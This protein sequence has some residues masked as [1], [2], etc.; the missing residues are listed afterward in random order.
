MSR[1]V[2]IALLFFLTCAARGDESK[3]SERYSG[4]RRDPPSRDFDF[5]H[6]RLECSFDWEKEEVEAA[7]THTCRAF[8]EGARTVELDQVGIQVRS[9]ALANGR[10]LSFETLPDKLRIDLGKDARRGE[11]VAFTVSYRARPKAG[12]YFRKPTE[13]DPDTPRQIWTQGEAEEA[14]HWI[15]C[16]D[17][18]SDKLTSE[19][20]VT[21]PRPLTAISNGRLVSTEPR[22][23]A[24]VFRWVQDKPHTTYLIVVVVGEFAAWKAEAEGIPLTAYAQKR[25]EANLA[26]SFE[27]TPDMIRFFNEKTGFPYPWAKYDQICVAGFTFGGMENTS[28]TTLNERTLHD[29]RASLDVSSLGLVAHELAHQWFGDLVTCKDWGDIWINE[30]FATFFE[31]LYTEHHL[32]WDEGVYERRGQA[33]SYKDEDRTEYRRP[34]ALRT[35]RRPEHLFDRHTYPKGARVLSMLRHVLGD[36]LFFAGIKRYLEKHAYGSVETG[37]FRVAMEEATGASLG[38]F[39]DQWLFSGGHPSYVVSSAWSPDTRMLEV[40]VEQTQKVDDLTPLFR[41]PVT[42]GVTQP[43]GRTEHRVWVWERKHVFAFPAAERPRLVRF[44]PGDWIL[45]DL[46]QSASR[47]ELLYQL[48]HDPD[49][50]GRHEAAEALRRYAPD[51]SVARA[52]VSRLEAE[53]FWGVRVMTSASLGSWRTDAVRKGLAARLKAEPKSAV[54]REI[55]RVLGELGGEEVPGLLREAIAA[56]PS[57]FVAADALRSLGKA[58]KRA[59]H[60]DAIQ[61]LSR[62]SH[63]DVV[64]AAAVEVLSMTADL[65]A[66]EQADVVRRIVEVARSGPSLEAR[67][68][69][70]RALARAG[71]GSDGALEALVQA[72]DD[73]SIHVRREAA[74]ALGELGDRRALPA[75]EARR[76]KET[77]VAIR[78]PVEVIERAIARIEGRT[79]LNALRD[80]VRRLRERN[81]ALERRVGELERRGREASF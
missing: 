4:P 23:D 2:A 33:Q 9:A 15:P 49:V 75:L 11:E 12:V 67:G 6:L 17:H 42:I 76:A 20:I 36:G 7:V 59:A 30:S 44:D 72:L 45:K 54:R 66:P 64:R 69:A 71:K 18:P 43:S 51:E 55:A 56:D 58:A 16:F 46:E 65:S 14:R 32:G 38:W 35:W 26:R 62:S 31:N 8:R 25:H 63:L 28:A 24:Q 19:V 68:A 10:A 70:L 77:A 41:M 1:P 5:L 29:E 79:D 80:E 3:R 53:P 50:M 57:Y 22:G 47:E 78:N 34:I 27:L 13:A 81:E 21:A 60:A 48:E 74:E 52:L 61:A 73:P 37:D 40:Q 39:F